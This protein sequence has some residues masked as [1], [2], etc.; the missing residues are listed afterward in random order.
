MLPAMAADP[1]SRARTHLANER[2][3]L[4]W[5]RTGITLVALGLAAAQFLGSPGGAARDVVRLLSTLVIGTGGLMAIAGAMR[6]FRGRREI[7]AT[8][9]QPASTSIAVT[10]GLALLTAAVAIGFVWLLHPVP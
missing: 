4:A 1:D 3:F 6:Y 8:R 7:D 5:F 2:T 10:A 9:F